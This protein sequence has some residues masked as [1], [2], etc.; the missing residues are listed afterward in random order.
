MKS[1]TPEFI[2]SDEAMSLLCISRTTLNRLIEKRRITAYKPTGR[3]LFNRD[4]LSEYIESCAVIPKQSIY[5]G[6]GR[7]KVKSQQPYIHGEKWV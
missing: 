7:R 3:L 6:T 4:E 5:H 2:T 1:K